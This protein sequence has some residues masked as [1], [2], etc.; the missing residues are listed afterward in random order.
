[1]TNTDGVRTLATLA[2]VAVLGGCG[3]RDAV[4]AGAQAVE[5]GSTTPAPDS[6]T[7]QPSGPPW[8]AYGVEDYTYT[9]RVRCFCPDAGVPITVTVTD[10]KAVDAVL[11]TKGSGRPAGAS[12]PEWAR[13]TINDVIEAANDT[14]ADTIEVRW[15]AGQDYPTSVWVDRDTNAIDEEIG[16]TIRDV[17]PA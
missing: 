14:K 7:A 15:P 12:A 10:G 17:D 16:Y 8:P 11:A 9:L 4:D 5:S 6:G 1:M 3:T 13:V 2:L